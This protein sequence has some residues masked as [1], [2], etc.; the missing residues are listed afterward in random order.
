MRFCFTHPVARGT[1]LSA[2]A[3]LRSRPSYEILFIV[4]P[5][6]RQYRPRLRVRTYFRVRD[7]F[8]ALLRRRHPG[9]TDGYAAAP[10]HLPAPEPTDRVDTGHP[11]IKS[12]R[13]VPCGVLKPGTVPSQATAPPTYLFL[14][15][16]TCYILLQSKGD[17]EI[18]DFA[19][20][21]ARA[22]IS[23]LSYLCLST[24]IHLLSCTGL[25]HFL[26]PFLSCSF[27]RGQL[28]G[29]IPDELVLLSSVLSLN[30]GDNRLTGSVFP[31]ALAALSKMNS[32]NVADNLLAGTLPV[33]IGMLPS[34]VGESVHCRFHSLLYQYQPLPVHTYICICSLSS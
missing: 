5:T 16:D 24:P 22:L 17:F 10:R 26:L 30:L 12:R 11:G 34:L 14:V 20:F 6:A 15:L 19:N 8:S 33:S 9:D 3:L 2:L 13:S 7:Y 31:D 29:R 18:I 21:G 32:Y 27:L 28:T 25:D 1:S 4:E 23:Y